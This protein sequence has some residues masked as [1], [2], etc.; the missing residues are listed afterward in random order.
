LWLLRGRTPSTFDI[1]PAER[2]RRLW[3]LIDSG[4]T[5]GIVDVSNGEPALSEAVAVA[6]HA[7]VKG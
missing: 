4:S 1:G 2:G 7:V 5:D 3:L 6:A